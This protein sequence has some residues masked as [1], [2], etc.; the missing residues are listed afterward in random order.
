MFKKAFTL[1]E[2][3]I[4]IGL[5]GIVAALTLPSMM[6]LH[7][8]AGTGPLLAKAQVSI[9][10]AISRMQLENL[11]KSLSDY[12]TTADL[13]PELKNYLFM[14]DSDGGYV[15]KDGIYF[16]ITKSPTIQIPVIPQAAGVYYA[17]VLVD[18]NGKNPPEVEGVDR[19][20]FTLTS[21]G[22]MVPIYCTEEI[23]N[24]NWKVPKDY[25]A[26]TC[27]AAMQTPA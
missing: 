18:V 20:Y 12:A 5:I 14:T 8:D 25:D 4:T 2:V 10:E 13:I 21:S 22:M 17:T 6:K 15:L 27:K 9:E 19:F 24:N 7:Q 3:L 1:A 26:A 23:A 11:D 16:E